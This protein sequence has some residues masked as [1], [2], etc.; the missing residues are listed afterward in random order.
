M[1]TLLVARYSE[2]PIYGKLDGVYRHNHD[3][4]RPVPS[5]P[6]TIPTLIHIQCVANNRQIK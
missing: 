1:Y 4:R 6:Y 3:W 5:I 2:K